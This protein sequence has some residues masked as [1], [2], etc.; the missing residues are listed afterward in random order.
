MKEVMK[1]SGISFSIIF[2]CLLV[3]YLHSQQSKV[4]DNGKTDLI[5]F[6]FDRPLQLYALLESV[7]KYVTG[8]NKT[9]VIYRASNQSFDHAYEIV[10]ERFISVSFV[11]QGDNPRADF[12]PFTLKAFDETAAEYVI[13]AV[14]DIVV[15][16]SIDLAACIDALEKTKA[17]GFYFRL[18]LN[19]NQCYPYNNR[20]QPL[21]ALKLVD[22]ALGIYSWQFSQGMLD[23]NYPNTVDMTL[24]RKKDIANDL[25]AIPFSFPNTLEGNWDGL[26]HGRKHLCGLCFEKSKIV[27]LPLNRVQHEYNNKVMNALSPQELLELFEQ[28]K[29]MDISPLAQIANKAAHMEYVPTFCAL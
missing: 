9:F 28:G 7:E 24:Y 16:D 8:L 23:W 3:F 21:P 10:R 17:Y 25:H 26:S 15:K 14:D 11:K 5:V 27:N 1:K 6:S 2:S 22:E 29:K 4:V 19:L 18:G 12:K 13:F 20:H